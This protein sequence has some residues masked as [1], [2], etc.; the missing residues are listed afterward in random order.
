MDLEGMVA[1][2]KKDP[3]DS[4]TIWYLI[5][6]PLCPQDAGRAGMPRGESNRTAWGTRRKDEVR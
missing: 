6:N 3:Y 4:G 2:R 5:K 1:K